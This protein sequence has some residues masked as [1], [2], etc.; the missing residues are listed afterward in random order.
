MLYSDGTYNTSY[1]NGF[2]GTLESP[3]SQTTES[4]QAGNILYDLQ[5]NGPWTYRT[6]R[7][8]DLYSPPEL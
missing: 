7:M 8:R 4:D 1:D 5:V 2:L 3:Y 6:F